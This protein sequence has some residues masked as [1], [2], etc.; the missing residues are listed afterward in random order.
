[1]T[2]GVLFSAN[3][4]LIYRNRQ[5]LF[6]S[7]AFPLLFL[8]ILGLSFG[9][10]GGSP[11]TIGVV[12]RAQ[13][14][15]SERLLDELDSLESIDVELWQDESEAREA[16]G[17]D[18]LY[19]L[20]VIPPDLAASVA[21]RRPVSF[22][23]VYDQGSSASGL[24]LGVVQRYLD[25][26]NLTLAGAPRLLTLDPQ[27]VLADRFTYLDFLLPGLVA[28]GIMTA[29]IFG[30]SAAMASYREQH[31]LRRLLAAPVRA[32]DFFGAMVL[33]YLMLAV[34]QATIIFAAGVLLFD[35]AVNGNP[36]YIALLILLGNAIF[37]GIGFIV[38]SVASSV[39]AAAGLGNAVIWPMMLLSG[40]FFETDN[41]PD[42]LRVAV[43]YLPLTP[44]V[45]SLRGVV[46]DSQSILEFPGELA[47]LGAWIVV[48]TGVA[49]RVFKFT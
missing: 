48:T 15:V 11:A 31:V 29:S 38:G 14:E 33:A 5:A 43:E 28:M 22:T 26:V 19:M 37:F 45:D 25:Q 47:L 12:D 13:D 36:G 8:V 17:D 49:L 46:L 2:F 44:M 10:D 40:V 24:F 23:L 34:V 27:G 39:Q 9:G 18:D 21:S 35:L 3:V 30:I 7:L 20:L 16:V 32:R 1:M 4:K 6:W 41:F 42:V